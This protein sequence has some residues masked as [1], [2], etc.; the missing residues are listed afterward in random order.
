MIPSDVQV[1]EELN[2]FKE[3]V[4]FAKVLENKY[5]VD[6]AYDKVILNPVYQTS[7]KLLWK[8]IDVKVIDGFINGFANY[9][10]RLSFTWRKLQTGVIQD[11]TAITIAGIAVIILF[12]IFV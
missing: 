11:Y 7:D 1:T 8:I 3:N 2:E 12:L 5:Y 10:Q 6:E 4:G 9:F